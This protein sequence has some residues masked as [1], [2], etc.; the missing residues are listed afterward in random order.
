M[1]GQHIKGARLFLHKICTLRVIYQE[2][3]KKKLTTFLDN[4]LLRQKVK[5]VF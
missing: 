4:K 5:K 1:E 3:L 2:N